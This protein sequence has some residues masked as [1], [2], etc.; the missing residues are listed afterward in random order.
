MDTLADTELPCVQ[1]EYTGKAEK[2][3]VFIYTDEVPVLW[4]DNRVD[5]DTAYLQIQLITPKNFNYFTLKH[6]IRNLLE[7]A[8]F[9]VTSTQSFLGDEYNGTDKVRQTI[10]ECQY[11]ETRTIIS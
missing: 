3:I 4:S 1:D 7:E 8:G 5:A 11:S 6:Q 2:Y 10:F 9:L